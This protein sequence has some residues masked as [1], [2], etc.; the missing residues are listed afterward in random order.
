MTDELGND[1]F[2]NNP[3]VNPN[4]QGDDQ[5]ADI[6]SDLQTQTK[7]AKEILSALLPLT[8]N[9]EFYK[10]L[11]ESSAKQ[12]EIAHEE[13]KKGK[14]LNTKFAKDLEKQRKEIRNSIDEAKSKI[15]EVKRL[16]KAI[17]QFEIAAKGRA[18]TVQNLR[19]QAD[20]TKKEVTKI[21]GE[22]VSL[23]KS[24]E[25]TSKKLDKVFEK[26]K[27][28]GKESESLLRELKKLKKNADNNAERIGRF[29]EKG[30]E[31]LDQ[32]QT[33]KKEVKGL[34]DS[35]KNATAGIQKWYK[36]LFER[37]GVKSEIDEILKKSKAHQEEIDRQLGE[38]AANRLSR[39]FGK[40]EE[41][42][43]KDLIFW[44]WS[45]FFLILAIV[46]IN[47]LISFSFEIFG[48]RVEIR[49]QISI[50]SPLLFLLGFSFIEYLKTRRFLDEY[51]FKNIS[52]VAMPAYV[53][54]IEERN[55]DA[56]LKY[57]IETTK[58]IYRNPAQ[59]IYGT[60]LKH[61]VLDYLADAIRGVFS[62]KGLDPNKVFEVVLR[63][64]IEDMVTK[65]D[66]KTG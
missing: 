15:Y 16:L 33:Q 18:E 14:G 1:N 36:S 40:K 58:D 49:H 4:P 8:D 48:I 21:K 45:V 10:D 38:A 2:D 50:I 53:E 34:Y 24:M 13:I 59:S 60:K 44:K 17:K 22:A 39:S 30:K 19:T 26:I 63:E 54:L 46:I 11:F 29:L 35:A 32:V 27:K 37:K 61:N 42:L 57:L 66:K 31:S 56:A 23:L 47:T 9:G 25:T 55:T 43:E 28:A 51:S 62:R 3:E 5:Y 64:K 65:C 52:A 7:E 12:I 41:K 20:E 6:L